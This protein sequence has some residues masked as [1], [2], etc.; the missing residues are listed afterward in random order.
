MKNLELTLQIN[1][2]PGDIAYA[3]LT[4]PALIEQH[5][6]AG[7]ILLVVDTCKPG[8]TKLVNPDLRFPEPQFTQKTE[9]IE[10]I[11][12]S[13]ANNYNNC[14]VYVLRPGDAIIQQLGDRYLGGWY[15]NTHDYGGCANM[16]YWL[17]FEFPTTRY[18]LHYDGDMLL[19]QE[20]GYS[21]TEEAIRLLQENKQAVAACPRYNTPFSHADES[22][23]YRHGVPF[24]RVKDG[25]LD[26][27]FSTRCLLIDKE[28]MQKY[29]PLLS[30][31]I[32]IETLAVKY[33]N[34]GY[35]RSPEIIMYRKIGGNNGRRLILNSYKSWTMHPHSKPP[36]YIANLPAIMKLVHAGVYPEGHTDENFELGKWIELIKKNVSA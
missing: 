21:W 23:S 30:G 13:I 18:V 5:P 4:V 16:A 22:P 33:L 2:S 6:E 1:L 12:T 26:T 14:D 8:R 36:E 11:A 9:Q 20:P 19:F 35:P 31:R 24:E 15:Y 10:A 34:R 25:W 32:L 17:G 28:R 29:L 27:F 3:A 7:R